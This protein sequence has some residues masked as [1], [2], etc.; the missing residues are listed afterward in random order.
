MKFNL[1]NIGYLETI[2]G[3]DSEIMNEIINIFIDQIPEFVTE[4]KSLLKK[5]DHYN[6]GLLAHKAKSSVAIMGL[7][8]LSIMLKEFEINAKANSEPEKYPVYI[9][10]FEND[11]EDAIIELKS[12]LNN[13]K[14]N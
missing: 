11:T 1:I 3:G 9:S 4:M 6:L 5:K 12:Y 10:R 14:P 8:E 13:N 2:T 7:E